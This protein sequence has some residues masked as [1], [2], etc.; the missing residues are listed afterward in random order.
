MAL[1]A[2]EQP[3]DAVDKRA[4]VGVMN[5]LTVELKKHC[6]RLGHQWY[7]RKVDGRVVGRKCLRCGWKETTDV[8]NG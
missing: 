1:E 2:G 4:I 7:E 5:V 8:H 3:A 6:V